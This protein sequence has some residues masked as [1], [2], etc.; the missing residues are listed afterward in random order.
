ME[1]G[2]LFELAI[3]IAVALGFVL[4]ARGLGERV[5]LSRHQ[6]LPQ[7]DRSRD[8][9]WRR[10]RRRRQLAVRL[11]SN[12][13]SGKLEPGQSRELE[14]IASIEV[15]GARA[16]AV[17]PERRVYKSDFRDILFMRKGVWIRIG[18]RKRDSS[19]H[20]SDDATDTPA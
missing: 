10:L 6:Q 17:S 20:F 2:F 4:S 15:H 11:P 9:D 18:A 19:L 7:L 8:F 14:I 1:L 5:F 13:D 16:D 12:A 3:L